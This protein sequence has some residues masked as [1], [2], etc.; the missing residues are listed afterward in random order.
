[1]IGVALFARKASAEE[2]LRRKADPFPGNDNGFAPP[3]V[4]R[5]E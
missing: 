5:G 2:A 1:M 3:P 4:P